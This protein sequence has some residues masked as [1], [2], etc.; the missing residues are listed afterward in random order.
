VTLQPTVTGTGCTTVGPVKVEPDGHV[1]STDPADV[2]SPFP[3]FDAK[4]RPPPVRWG[5]VVRRALIDRLEG[6]PL[7]PVVTVTAPAGYG[8]TTLL[9]QWAERRPPVAWVTL[10]AE[11]RDPIVLLTSVATAVHRIVPLGPGIFEA[12]AAPSAGVV[13]ARQLA[14]TLAR[15]GAGITLMLDQAEVLTAPSAVDALV[16]LALRLP[17]DCTLVLAARRTA[18]LPLARWRAERRLLELGPAD[19]SM[20]RPEAAELVGAVRPDLPAAAIEALHRR[21]EG[22]PAVLYLGALAADDERPPDDPLPAISG[23]DRFLAD[24]LRAELL[25]PLAA[26]DRVFLGQTAILD[27]LSGPLCD[28]VTEGTDSQR[29]LEDLERQNLLVTALDTRRHWFRYHQLLRDLLQSELDRQPA[30]RVA[31]LHGRAARWF[32]EHD[33]PVTAVDHAQ[34]ADDPDLVA[35]LVLANAQPVW[36]TGR[37]DTVMRWMAWFEAHGLVER[38]AGVAVHGALIYALL[39]RAAEAER[40][41]AGAEVAPAVDDVGDGNSSAATRAYLRALRAP[42]G[43][44]AAAADARTA[45]HLLHPGSPYRATMLFTDGVAQ[46]LGGDGAAADPLLAR[47]ADAAGRV[48]ANPL[49]AMALTYRGVHAVGGGDWTAAT[50][51]AGDARALLADGRFDGY[52]S[53]AVV[54]AWLARVAI[55]QGRTDLGRADLARAAH[56]RPLLTWALPVVSTHALVE[57]ARAYLALHD[58]AGARAVLRQA[59]EILGQRPRL[60]RLP[61]DVEQLK[62]RADALGDGRTGLSALTAGERRILPLLTTHLTLV[63]ISERLY[64]SHNTVKSHVASIYRKLGVRNRA[65]AVAH[66]EPVA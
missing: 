11:D 62:A 63:Q 66:L 54:Y 51:F 20:T 30:D 57:Q 64:V 52:W 45:G 23:D 61:A 59:A 15:T 14:A 27:R 1:R 41:A 8:K 3:V 35:R 34:Q 32:A 42:D 40:W 33:G 9:A 4:L 58:P 6:G 24:Y 2:R 37:V 19:L 60:G 25:A 17:G 47:A 31:R 44:V 12:L 65:E 55:H 49:A 13:V 21:A 50:A 43:L 7:P 56:L 16:E 28:A 10:D 22:W 29:R 53:S 18:P 26:E 48:G 39:G 38:Y 36:A 5:L 46:L